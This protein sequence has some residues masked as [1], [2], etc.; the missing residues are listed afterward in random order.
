MIGYCKLF[1][2]KRNLRSSSTMTTVVVPSAILMGLDD[3]NVSKVTLN[4]SLISNRT[5]S[6]IVILNVLV[7]LPAGNVILC[8]SK[9]KS[10]PSTQMNEKYNTLVRNLANINNN[11]SNSLMENK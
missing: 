5:S 7:I 2:L 1:T 6:C 8:G 11:L 4:V 10:L 3:E 9:T